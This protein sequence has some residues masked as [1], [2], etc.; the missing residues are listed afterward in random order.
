ML[1]HIRRRFG[2]LGEEREAWVREK[3]ERNYFSQ[4]KRE[5]VEWK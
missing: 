3:E 4:T 2:R 1:D 5:K